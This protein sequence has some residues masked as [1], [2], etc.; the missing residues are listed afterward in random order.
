MEFP[1][2]VRCFGI[3][4]AKGTFEGREFSS[5]TFHLETSLAENSSGRSMGIVT[6]PF[7]FGTASEY[8]KWKHLQNAIFPINVAVVFSIEAGSDNRAVLKLIDIKPAAS[9]P[10]QSAPAVPKV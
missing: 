2:E 10:G 5:T 3:K 6:R 9:R 1:T 8:E 4:E 7:K